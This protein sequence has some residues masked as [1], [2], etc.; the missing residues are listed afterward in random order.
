M[1]YIYFLTYSKQNNNMDLFSFTKFTRSLIKY[2]ASEKNAKAKKKFWSIWTVLLRAWFPFNNSKS[3]KA[4]LGFGAF[5]AATSIHYL[6]AHIYKTRLRCSFIDFNAFSPLQCFCC[7][8]KIL[9]L[10]KQFKLPWQWTRYFPFKTAQLLF[11]ISLLLNMHDPLALHCFC[12]PENRVKIFFYRFGLF[13]FYL[14][15]S[16]L[17]LLLLLRGA[18]SCTT[19]LLTE[20]LKIEWMREQRTCVVYVP[21]INEQTMLFHVH[22][23]LQCQL[24]LI[25]RIS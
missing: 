23:K 13:C 11:S 2:R 6:N 20:L 14:I 4:L 10:R 3:H 16:V 5:S 7:Q 8:R 21:M 1:L 24:L 12:I 18:F 22:S 19:F 25:L 15:W 17:L 9:S